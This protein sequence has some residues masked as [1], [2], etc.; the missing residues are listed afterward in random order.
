[1]E[2]ARVS[3]PWRVGVIGIG[4]VGLPL[5]VL[6][7]RRSHRVLGIDVNQKRVD[8]VNTGQSYVEGISSRGLARLVRRGRLRASSDY[9]H[10]HDL[11][12]VILCLPTPVDENG[13]P[14]LSALV[15]ATR[16]VAPRLKTGALVV[17]ESSS[18]PGTTEDLVRPLLE[19]AGRKVGKDFYLAYSP[20]RVNPAAPPPLERIPKLLSGVTLGCVDMAEQLYRTAFRR[21]VRVSSPRVAEMAKLMENA[22][23]LVN[24]AFVN[25]MAQISHKLGL[26]IWEV[27]E[28]AGTK[29]FGYTP[30]L[31]GPGVGGH[32][33]PVDPLYLQWSARGAGTDSPLIAA[34]V[35]VNRSM[36]RYVV[37]RLASHLGELDGKRLLLLGVAYKQN[38]SDV[39]GSPALDVL[40]KLAEAGAEIH[41]H[42]PHIAALKVAGR[43]YRSEVLTTR[44]LR[45][46]EAVVVLT[47]HDSIDYRLVADEARWVL[48]TRNALSGL[49]PLPNL[50]RL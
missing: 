40:E 3:S 48:D 44:L 35:E 16:S 2:Q 36:P 6:L 41:Y 29:P 42:D 18:Y 38:V 10:I 46:V 5:A 28:A 31:P 50:E 37:K 12:A 25:D 47:A 45:T 15:E 23:R 30:Y 7:A 34:A 43:D 26:D 21:L 9:D 32:C 14:D 19:A 24:I 4:Y 49:G 20:E 11:D 13:L 1:M 27:L 17:L 8:A 22:H 33:I 39:R